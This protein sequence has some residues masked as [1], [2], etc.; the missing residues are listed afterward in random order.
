MRLQQDPLDINLDRIREAL[1][2]HEAHLSPPASAREAAVAS[3]APL[4]Q[5]LLFRRSP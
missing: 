1:L 2:R 3:K 4:I 5:R